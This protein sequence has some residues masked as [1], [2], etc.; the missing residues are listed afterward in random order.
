MPLQY[1]SAIGTRYVKHM[2]NSRAIILSHRTKIGQLP[3]IETLKIQI[4]Y[5][6]IYPARKNLFKLMNNSID[7]AR[8]I[9]SSAKKLPAD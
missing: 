5:Y 4:L 9:R 6:C 8:K 3:V 7:T 1:H 2:L